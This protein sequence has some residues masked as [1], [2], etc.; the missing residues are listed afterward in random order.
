MVDALGQGDEE[1]DDQR[2]SDG[3]GDEVPLIAKD[4]DAAEIVFMTC[5][6]TAERA[7]KLRAELDQNKVVS[8][9]NSKDDVVAKKIRYGRP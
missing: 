9:E 2:V 6:P 8:V 5:G 3:G 4:L 7:T 1:Q